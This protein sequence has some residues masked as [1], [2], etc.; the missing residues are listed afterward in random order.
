MIQYIFKLAVLIF[1]ISKAASLLGIP[2]KEGHKSH[3]NYTLSQFDGVTYL[4]C[5]GNFEVSQKQ[6]GIVFEFGKVNVL[7]DI[8]IPT[9]WIDL[10]SQQPIFMELSNGKLLDPVLKD[11]LR[12]VDPRFIVKVFRYMNIPDDGKLV[13]RGWE[14]DDL[15]CVPRAIMEETKDENKLV[16]TYQLDEC[17]EEEVVIMVHQRTVTLLYSKTKLHLTEIDYRY[18]KTHESGEVF[19]NKATVNF[20]HFQKK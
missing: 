2:L 10:V 6:A 5:N 20:R 4:V 12:A 13:E 14:V 16:L 19:E 8:N 1:S 18:I 11:R 7:E 17:V 9:S 3:F 15:N